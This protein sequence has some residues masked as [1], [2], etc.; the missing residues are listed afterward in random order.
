MKD[1]E[2]ARIIIAGCRSFNNYDLLCEEVN[3]ILNKFFDQG[4]TKRDIV[5]ISGNA[6]GADMCGERFAH[7]HGFQIKRFPAEW[8]I[9]GKPAGMIRNRQMAE[10]ASEEGH[11]GMLIAFWNGTSRGTK[12]MI[13][14]AKKY[15]LK[16][17]VVY[18]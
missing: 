8:N 6:I 7:E 3:K 9:Y 13:D 10:Y 17:I 18:I 2:K 11:D 16:T 12:N 5:F 14:N 4:Y 1:K 15:K